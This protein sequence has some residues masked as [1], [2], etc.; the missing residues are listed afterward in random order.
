MTSKQLEAE[1][2]CK[3]MIRGRGSMRDKQKVKIEILLK[4]K[5]YRIDIGRTTSR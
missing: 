3:I 1:T 5:T 4:Y 2:D